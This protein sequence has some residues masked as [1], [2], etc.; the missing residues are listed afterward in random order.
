MSDSVS[1][2]PVYRLV[3]AN[4]AARVTAFEKSD[5]QTKADIAY[6]TKKS[7]SL[8]TP[9]ALLKDYRSLSIVLDAFGMKSALPQTALLRKLMTEDPASKTSVAHK[10]G[11]PTYL[12]FA[13]AM[14]QFKQQP[15][16][17]QAGVDAVVK[18]LSTQNFEA[19]QD[20]QSPGMS[21]ALYF[22]R[23][24]Q[25]LTT[26]TQL[27]SDPKLLKVAQAATN[28]PDQFGSLDYSFQVKLLSKQVTMKNFQ[29]AAY[30]DKFVSRYL[31]VNSASN[32]S[33]VDTTGALSILQGSGSSQNILGALLPQ[34]SG[35]NSVLSLFA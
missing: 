10:L 33:T 1:A 9:D 25:S 16:A 34:S 18:A 24:I 8:T 7:P 28:M 3:S 6:F 17:N 31:A 13:S 30:V 19:A 22:K 14:G 26:I 20:A 29:S 11:N 27:M 5:P 35:S 32:A 12:R 15:L 21:N 23:N 2:L 4:E